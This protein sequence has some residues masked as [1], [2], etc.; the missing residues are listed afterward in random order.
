MPKWVA[1]CR[2]TLAGAEPA[3]PVGKQCD[4]PHPCPFFTH[5]QGPQPEYPVTS[6]YY[7]GKIVGE[8]LAEGITDL[9]AIPPG[10]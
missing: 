3:N 9:R 2:E 7:G 1:Q 6:L 5:C 10:G 8:L 4:K